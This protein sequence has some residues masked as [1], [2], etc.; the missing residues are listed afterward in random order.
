MRALIFILVSALIF[1]VPQLLASDNPARD[2]SL[3][4]SRPPGQAG[5]AQGSSASDPEAAGPETSPEIRVAISNSSQSSLEHGQVVITAGAGLT[6]AQLP[7]GKI[8]AT[9]RG[10]ENLIVSHDRFGFYTRVSK[11]WRLAPT[12]L[13]TFRNPLVIRP[14]DPLSPLMVTSIVRTSRRIA[15]AYRGYLELR[16]SPSTGKLR[17]INVVHLEEYLKG[18]VPNEM[19]F[20]YSPE[21]L[22]AQAVAARSYA[23]YSLNAADSSGYDV[24]DSTS[25]QVYS[26]FRSEQEPTTAAVEATSGLVATYDREVIYAVFSANCGGY[27]ENGEN[28]WS[29]PKS[30]AFPGTVRPYLRSV[31]CGETVANLET[32]EGARAFF[33]GTFAA[34]DADSKYYRWQTHWTRSQ[35]EQILNKNLAARYAVQEAR[36]FITPAFARGASIGKL[37]G[38]KALQRGPSGKILALE[39]EGTAGAWVIRKEFNIRQILRDPETGGPALSA[40]MVFDFEYDGSG[41]IT[42]ITARGGG[43]GHGAGLCQDGAGGMARRGSNFVEILKHYYT[44]VSLGTMPLRLGGDSRD[45]RGERSAGNAPGG[46]EIGRSFASPT[47]KGILVIDNAGLSQL[48]IQVNDLPP[49]TVTAV[50]GQLPETGQP[51]QAGQLQETS[52]PPEASEVLPAGQASPSGPPQGVSQTMAQSGVTRLDLAGMLKPGLNHISFLVPTPSGGSA[53]VMVE[54]E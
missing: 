21:A 43:W 32:E 54:V 16:P 4:G 52:R 45:A 25:S 14:L 27:T 18:V 24:T 50:S 12:T 7:S 51:P 5:I 49:V 20:T 8:L 15:P 53:R 1:S 33:T 42:G 34:D 37:L 30:N 40:G 38:L 31:P 19:P 17:V 35:L 36:S 39:V 26:G 44:G 29:D 47:G 48:A 22:K 13:G 9:L 10:N 6:V 28:I 11:A 41:E 3:N 2:N 23:I 46:K